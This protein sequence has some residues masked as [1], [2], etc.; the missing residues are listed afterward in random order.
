MRKTHKRILIGV[1]IVILVLG[2]V[3]ALALVQAHA[4]LSR[5]YAALEADGRPMQ[6]AEV[7]PPGIPDADNA[8]PLFVEAARPLKEQSR[9]I[10]DLLDRLQTLSSRFM[11]GSI[12]QEDLEEFEAYMGQDLVRSSLE[13]FEEGLQRPGCRFIRDY[14]RGLFAELHEARDIRSLLRIRRAKNRLELGDETA[15]S[16]WDAVYEQFR[17][18]EALRSEPRYWNQITRYS[19]ASVTCREIQRLCSVNPP[20]KQDCQRL[21]SILGDLDDVTPLIRALDGERL[22]WGERLFSLPMGDLYEALL[23]HKFMQAPRGVFFRVLFAYIKFKPRLVGDHATYLEAM[24]RSA[25]ILQGP[26]DPS[27]R[28]ELRDLKVKSM[29]TQEFMPYADFGKRFHCG[30]AANAHITRAGLALLQYRQAHGRYPPT[31]DALELKGLMDPY[32][33]KPLY[34]HAEGE[35]FSIYSVGENQQDNQGRPRDRKHKEWDDL[36]WHFPPLS[37]RASSEN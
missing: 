10:R 25:Q 36:A 20:D 8:G 1:G 15:Q 22:F 33:E 31:L 28:E 21:Q 34:Y 9:G 30:L 32:S 3:Y 29:L 24:R 2:A 17:L 23:E 7:I 11:N 12:D 16:A 37:Q 4:R 5:A 27:A 35:A 6:A 13:L 26:Y 18:V 14:D 19:L